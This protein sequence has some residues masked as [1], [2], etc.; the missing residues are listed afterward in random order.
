[1]GTDSATQPPATAVV[2]GKTRLYL[3][4]GFCAVWLLVLVS[5]A[6]WTT[7]LSVLNPR[8]IDRASLIVTGK[9]SDLASGRISIEFVW[10]GTSGEKTVVV[11]ELDRTEATL[12]TPW[13]FPLVESPHVAGKYAVAPYS[14]SDR[15]QDPNRPQGLLI[16][17]ASP[18]LEQQLKSLLS[19][20]SE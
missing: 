9:P 3:V 4:C 6:I 12:G 5:L 2:P 14:E 19:A 7:N 13:I 17:P 16:Y 15:G 18:E 1:M 8:Q 10:K 20:D 11:E